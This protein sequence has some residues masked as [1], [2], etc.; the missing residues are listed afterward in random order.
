[1]VELAPTT[2]RR[3][4][5]GA[6]AKAPVAVVLVPRIPSPS[7]RM[8]SALSDD[9][10]DDPVKLVR[11]KAG[12]SLSRERYRRAE[13]FFPREGPIAPAGWSDFLYTVGISVQLGLSAHLLDVG[14]PDAW[15]ARH[16][17]L[18]I[19]KSLAYANATGFNHE[20]PHM[21][22]LALVLTP[23]WKWNRPRLF[24]EAQPDD[25]GFA[26]DEVRVLLRALLDHVQRVTGHKSSRSP[27]RRPVN[28]GLSA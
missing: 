22:R 13:E 6:L 9:Y 24:G 15:C 10:G 28:S 3:A 12:R 27:N 14:F 8:L 11:S 19:A 1:M 21:A 16:I 25:G 2:S 26:P 5:L 20:C 4:L 23:Y 7:E 18:R 17:G